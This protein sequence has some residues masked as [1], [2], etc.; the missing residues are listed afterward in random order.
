VT[1]LPTFTCYPGLD[2]GPSL[3]SGA[4]SARP[5]PYASNADWIAGGFPVPAGNADYRV[6]SVKVVGALTLWVEHLDGTTGHVRFEPSALT[7]VFE[8]LGNP[9]HF[10]Q[11]FVEDGVVQ[12][13]GDLDLAPDNMH[14]HL[15]A[16]GEWILQ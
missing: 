7:G 16:F 5:D 10:E 15:A 6:A 8:V 12:W 11:A 4:A 1:N 9:T 14:R 13:P 2:P 3:L